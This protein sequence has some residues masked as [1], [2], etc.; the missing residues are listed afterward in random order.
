[1]Y[2]EVPL[3]TLFVELTNGQYTHYLL[4]IVISDSLATGV[5]CS[6]VRNI[7]HT[8]RQSTQQRRRVPFCVEEVSF[9]LKESFSKR[10]AKLDLPVEGPPINTYIYI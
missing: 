9:S 3:V 1:L 7:S 5:L 6:I 10:N 2:P 4:S 8:K